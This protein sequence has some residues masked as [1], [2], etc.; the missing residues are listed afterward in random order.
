MEKIV[1]NNIMATTY[2]DGTCWVEYKVGDKLGYIISDKITEKDSFDELG[3]KFNKIIKDQLTGKPDISSCG[4]FLAGIIE[5]CRQSDNEMWFVET[6]DLEDVHCIDPE[7]QE[8]FLEDLEED[9]KR[10]GL[11]EYIRVKE[12][13]NAVTVYG[14]VITMFLF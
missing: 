9:I 13:C 14:G 5:D 6:E 7:N 1:V 3:V 8:K 2:E 4:E 10:L 11:S 12:D